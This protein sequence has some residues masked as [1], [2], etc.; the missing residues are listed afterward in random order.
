MY[1][2]LYFIMY[3]Y[4]FNVRAEVIDIVLAFKYSMKK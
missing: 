4:V 2:A 3:E 1:Q